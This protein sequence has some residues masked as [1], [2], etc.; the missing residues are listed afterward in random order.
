MDYYY[1]YQKYKKKYINKKNAIQM[2]GGRIINLDNFKDLFKRCLHEIPYELGFNLLYDNNKVSFEITRGNESNISIPYNNVVIIHTHPG[3]L[4][5]T[6]EYHPPT[7]GDYSQACFDYFRGN[8]MGIVVE[9]AGI[10][11]YTPNENLIKEIEKI[12]PEDRK[13]VV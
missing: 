7:Q 5:K 9:K 1:K 11:F 4:Y 2:G 8:Q 3:V 6:F 12:Q 13:S 10:W